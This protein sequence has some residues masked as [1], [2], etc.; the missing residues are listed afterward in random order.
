VPIEGIRGAIAIS[1]FMALMRDGSVRE[2]PYK[3]SWSTPDFRN[4]VAVASDG[5]NRVALLADGRLM[6][7]G[8]KR[9]Y[10]NG[11]V[12]RATLGKETA[13]SCAAKL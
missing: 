2:F 6:A 7:W 4:A 9:W 5:I 11:P 10:P 1:P 13:R 12:T 8:H 3:P